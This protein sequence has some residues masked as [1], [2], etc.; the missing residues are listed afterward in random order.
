M[1]DG[2]TLGLFFVA[3]LLLA[4]TPGPGMLYVLARSIN[5]GV[6]E[7]LV[8]TGGTAIGGLFHVVAAACG[9]SALLAASD[10]SDLECPRAP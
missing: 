10:E 2:A 9:L 4:V 8:S 6:R 1:P 5:G 3:A 7:G